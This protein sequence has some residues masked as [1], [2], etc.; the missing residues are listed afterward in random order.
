MLCDFELDHNTAEAAKN[1]CCGKGEG[2]IGHGTVTGFGY[3]HDL[4]K[5]IRTYWIVPHIIK[6]LQNFWLILVS[7]M[8]YQTSGHQMV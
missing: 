1:I 4:G 3:L 2:A 6:M 7:E 5:S 8:V